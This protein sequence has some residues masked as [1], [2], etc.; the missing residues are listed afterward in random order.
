[1]SKTATQKVD[2]GFGNMFELWDNLIRVARANGCV[3]EGQDSFVELAGDF[4]EIYLEYC[5]AHFKIS[6]QQLQTNH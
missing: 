4:A 1:M 2:D 6:M 3:V 5:G